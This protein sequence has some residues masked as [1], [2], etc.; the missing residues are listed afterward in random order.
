VGRAVCSKAWS[1]RESDY[2]LLW[3]ARLACIRM[4]F[5][6]GSNLSFV[7]L[8][9][10]V[11]FQN[12]RREISSRHRCIIGC[13]AAVSV[14]VVRRGQEKEHADTGAGHKRSHYRAASDVDHDQLLRHARGE[15]IQGHPGDKDHRE[16]PSV[17]VERSRHR[18]VRHR[19]TIARRRHCSHRRRQDRATVGVY[20]K[21]SS[22][23]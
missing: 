6:V 3:H 12:R 11:L 19:D 21:T 22:S 17:S 14:E 7:L 23:C 2:F 5:A 9:E 1:P 13:R 8:I 15:R 4:S 10:V 20:S 16:R 18:Y